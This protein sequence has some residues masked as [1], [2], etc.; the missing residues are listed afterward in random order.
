MADQLDNRPVFTI[1]MGCNGAGKSAWKRANQNR[2][3]ERY[4]DKDSIADGI[5]G[6]DTADARERTDAYVNAEIDKALDERRNFGIESTY[7]GRPGRALVERALEAGYRIEGVHIGTRTPDINNKRI[8]YRVEHQTGHW[9]DPRQIPDR[10]RHSL[11]NLRQTAHRF[12]ELTIVDNSA[13]SPRGVPEPKT[14][15]VLER[16]GRYTKPRTRADGRRT[17]DGA[18]S[19]RR[20]AA[21]APNASAP[22]A[23]SGP[24][25]RRAGETLRQPERQRRPS[26]SRCNREEIRQWQDRQPARRRANGKHPADNKRRNRATAATSTE[27]ASPGASAWR[28]RPSP[29]RPAARGFLPAYSG[30]ASASRSSRVSSIFTVTEPATA[31][32]PCSRTRVPR[33]RSFSSQACGSQLVITSAPFSSG[34]SYTLT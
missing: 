16:G 27:S 22:E 9:I 26:G 24:T 30:A 14:E 15:L 21:R 3:P 31:L 34:S 1:V 10:Y 25:R 11:H 4:F 33:A 28:V 23:R 6:W 32:T 13:E 17:G 2:L 29:D 7:S 18:S 20:R 12:D 19:R 5:G 8:K